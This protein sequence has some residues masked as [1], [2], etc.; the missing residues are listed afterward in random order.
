PISH[1]HP[2][3]N[4][5]HIE[6]FGEALA[7]A[8]GY[9]PWWASDHDKNWN[10]QT[11]AANCITID[12]G[13]GQKYRDTSAKGKILEFESNEVYDYTLGDASNCYRGLI[14][15]WHRHV[16]HIRPGVFVLFDDLDA[17]KPVTYEWWIHAL[18]EMNI[19]KENKII[20]IAQGDARLKVMFLQSGKLGFTQIKGFP[21]APPEHGE[22]DQYHIYASANPKSKTGK[23]I[24]LLVPFKNG[25][26]PEI[27]VNN[28]IEKPGKVSLE[29]NING[30]KYYISYLPDVKVQLVE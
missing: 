19:D 21:E 1:A 24:T 26:E 17:P 22:P 3:E 29:L 5:F 6:A 16:V 27:E 4:A 25:K 11:K 2:D 12:G 18:S 7:V 28:L 9:Y 14:N 13:I 15:K 30:K 23:F 8:T 10:R 20:N